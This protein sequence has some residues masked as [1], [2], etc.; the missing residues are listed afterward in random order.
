MGWRHEWHPAIKF[1]QICIHKSAKK[2]KKIL[3][4]TAKTGIEKRDY[5]V[6]ILYTI[7]IILCEVL[8]RQVGLLRGSSGERKLSFKLFKIIIQSAISCS[9]LKRCELC[10]KLLPTICLSVWPFW[11]RSGVFNV[12]F[13]HISHLVLMFLLLTLSN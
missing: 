11:H 10:S 4:K 1:C 6:K 7:G 2:K 13:E 5:K 3:D 12:N 8:V 9:K